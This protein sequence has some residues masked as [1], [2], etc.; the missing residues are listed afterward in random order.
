MITLEKDA[1]VFRFPEVHAEAVLEI[2]FQRTLRI[3]DDGKTYPL[4]PGLGRFPL[5][6]VDDFA[7]DV[8]AT[9]RERGGVMLPMYQAEA[10]W[11][12]FSR[13]GYPMLVKVAAGKINAVNGKPWSESVVPP[14]NQ[15][16]LVV[17][18]QPW[19]D[20]YCTD[21]GIIRQFVAMPLGAGYSPEEQLTGTGEFGGIQILVHPVKGE[22]WER[23]KR[24][25]STLRSARFLS[26]SKLQEPMVAYDAAPDMA[27]GMGGQMAQE[28][29]RDTF[30]FEDWELTAR[31]RCFVHLTN[32]LVWRAITGQEPPT[33]P[34]TAAEYTRHGLPWFDYYS[35]TPAVDGAETLKG[36][37]S[38]TEKAKEQ[39][40]TPLPE[41]E[42]V[43]PGTV[44][45][46]GKQRPHNVVREG[47]F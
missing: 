30:R 47:S 24:E 36:L 14:P 33:T 6:H 40:G 45:K 23:M 22:A 1:L 46:L 42:S 35:D 25:R 41:N 31:A 7:A 27:L 18:T 5:R 29:L 39:G 10:L 16:Y 32:S 9:W 34:A 26:L 20:G 21:K 28:I 19:L 13:G 3:P 17:P 44:V 12:S 15:D 38:I 2:N 4:P 37:K 8:P 11:L 43:E